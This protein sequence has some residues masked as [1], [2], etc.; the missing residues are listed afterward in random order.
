MILRIALAW[1]SRRMVVPALVCLAASWA[2][3]QDTE[4]AKTSR[5]AG[6]PLPAGAQRVLNKEV[7]G[8]AVKSLEALAKQ[9]NKTCDDPEVLVW[10]GA[11]KPET[12]AAIKE[13]AAQLEK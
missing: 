5:L 8:Q 11:A 1:V 9:L 10:V 7:A 13:V 4:Q 3:C 6:I 2:M 12:N